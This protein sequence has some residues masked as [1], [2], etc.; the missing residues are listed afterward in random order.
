[1]PTYFRFG[2]GPFRFSQRV[3]RTQAQKRAAAKAQAQRRQ[4][5]AQR[6]RWRGTVS[7]NGVVTAR[8]PEQAQV[9]ILGRDSDE[10]SINV[11]G[12][13]VTIPCTDPAVTEGQGVHLHYRLGDWKLR[14]VTVD[15]AIAAQEAERGC[16]IWTM[17]R[18]PR[19]EGCHGGLVHARQ[20]DPDSR[21]DT[22]GLRTAIGC[23]RSGAV[24]QR[25]QGGA[26]MCGNVRAPTGGEC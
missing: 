13:T 19:G 5:Q 15:P 2:F 22:V 21:S 8:T 11:I 4:A 20:L 18:R 14:G 26:G 6:Q 25:L 23:S 16:D 12:Q 24:L 9:R 17:K 10:V 1:M 3:G 7:V